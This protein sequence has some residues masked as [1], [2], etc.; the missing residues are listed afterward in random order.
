M[1]AA[2]GGVPRGSLGAGGERRWPGERTDRGRPGRA[3]ASGAAP[4][5]RSPRRARSRSPPAAR[6]D[7]ERARGA[8][9]STARPKRRAA[10][11]RGAAAPA[12]GAA[13]VCQGEGFHAGR[14]L[15]S[16]LTVFEQPPA[17]AEELPHHGGRARPR[18]V[19]RGAAARLSPRGD[20][21]G[22]GRA[23]CPRGLGV[24]RRPGLHARPARTG[25]TKNPLLFHRFCI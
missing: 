13:L 4:S 17:F 20:D 19:V 16:P 10:P 18:V 5:R 7:R 25:R 6:G 23:G 15:P 12:A 11:A 3:A 1:V 22:T 24:P 2:R 21:G 9:R 8:G 14:G